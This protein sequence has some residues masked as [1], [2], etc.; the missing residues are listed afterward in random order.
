M[1]YRIIRLIVVAF[2]ILIIA[3]A[4]S[5]GTKDTEIS[6]NKDVEVSKPTVYTKKTLDENAIDKEIDKKTDTKA[7]KRI[8][9][10]QKNIEERPKNSISAEAYI[11]GNLE[12]G[13]IYAVQNSTAVF[14][15]ASLS[16]LV[17]AL[18]SLHTIPQDKEIVITESMLLAYGEAGHLKEGE[19][20]KVNELYYP[21]LLES[22]NDAAEALAQTYGYVDFI[23]SM[24]LFVAEL[25]MNYTS[26]K[27][28]SGLSSGN[29]SNANDLFTLA[30]YIYKNEKDLL[31]ITRMKSMYLS[32]T[33]LHNSHEWKTIN[34]FAYDP[35]FIGGKTGRTIE[36]KESM[37]SMFNYS[38]NN[39][40]YPLVI[41][42]LR[43]EF[44]DREKD[45]GM[46]FEKFIEKIH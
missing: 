21:L 41:I 18:I 24:N 30:K 19:I 20:F 27:D 44:S 40:I 38:Y 12:T 7:D 4:A 8:E 35:N 5:E 14:P 33:T 25:G 32:T 2:L 45:S 3:I 11:M 10:V 13:E 28:A 26:F 42:V 36:A 23:K 16:K 39:K 9:S 6:A 17:T 34:P 37:I 22:S 43:S 31:S 1:N 29:I 15:I 46:L